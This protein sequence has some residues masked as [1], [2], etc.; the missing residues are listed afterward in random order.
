MKKND[1]AKTPPMGWN[2]YDYYN[3]SVTEE[4]IKRN[5]DYMAEHLKPYG[6]EYIVVD[7]EWYSCHK[8][9]KND[10]E[11]YISFVDFAMDEYSRLLPS[12][13]R[14]PSAEGGKG[15]K[16]L[17]DYVHSK[18]LKFGIHIMRGIPRIAAHQHMPLLGTELTADKIANPSSI[19]FWNPGMYGVK[20]EKPEAQL[21]YDS[22]FALS[23]QWG[24]DFVKCDD[25]CRM[26]MPSAREEIRMLHRAI[27]KCGRPMVLS[28]SP[29]AAKI[30]EAWTYEENSNMWRITDDFWDD[31]RLLYAMFERCEVWQS[32]VSEGNFPDCDMLPV[33]SIGK[34]HFGERL[35]RFTKDEQITM[36]S[37]W[38]I[39]KSPMMIGAELP[40]LDD[41]TKELLTNEK[42]LGLLRLPS[43]A[44]Q[45]A[46]DK[47]HAI[48]M[49]R[50]EDGTCYLALFNLSE[51]EQELTVS[52]ECLGLEEKTDRTATEL[53]TNTIINVPKHEIKAALQKHSAKICEFSK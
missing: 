21:Y 37:L 26:D 35:C 34:Y 30:E 6:W 23:A 48:W 11:Q 44:R 7:I 14:F 1:W 46:R 24:V 40:K 28:L 31:W 39:F 13:L 8:P 16:P 49:N 9:R 47:K 42:V 32:H 18:G 17:A 12:T 38:A 27:E 51:E 50:A 5:A 20:T 33:G 25:I 43:Q 19:C 3:T 52:L 4:D 53:W 29:G 41:W 45:L 2:S 10:E 15:F 36:M 22:I